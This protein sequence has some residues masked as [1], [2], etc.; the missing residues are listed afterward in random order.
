[1]F[2]ALV[3]IA[4]VGIGTMIFCLVD[5]KREAKPNLQPQNP[6]IPVATP[7]SVF[8]TDPALK[9][10]KKKWPILAQVIIAANCA[11]IVL[12]VFSV[13]SGQWA[14]GIE[15]AIS[16]VLFWNLY[17]FKKWALYALDVLW[18]ISVL[19]AGYSVATGHSNLIFTIV[20]PLLMLWY[21]N[22]KPIKGLLEK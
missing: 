9:A 1:M 22:T 11:R 7:E 15:P 6:E 2:F 18:V 16:A 3:A 20:F 14:N 12:G 5:F 8:A 19:I 10:P 13:F 17:K 21:F 4:V